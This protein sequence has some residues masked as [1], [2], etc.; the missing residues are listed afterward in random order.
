MRLFV[1]MGLLISFVYAD[2][3]SKNLQFNGVT[4]SYKNKEI[5]IKRLRD[6]KC[7]NVGITP[8]NIFGGNLSGHR[9]PKE[10]KR[11][12]VTS[13]GVVQS[14]KIDDD[15]Q[16]VGE[17]EVLKF[18]QLLDFE[19]E[20]YIVVDARSEK[21][22]KKISI[23]H[24]V[25]VQFLHIKYHEDYF[26]SLEKV[27]APLGVKKDKK[28]KLDFSHAKNAI[29]Y[30]NANWCTQSANMIRELVKLGYPKDKLFWYRGGLQDW[31]GAGFTVSKSK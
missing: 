6:P 20:K 26:E 30:C 12:F 29:I 15:I 4:T 5:F 28:G 11:S 24:A 21:W 8:E 14:M 13:L 16:T 22:F 31:I 19:P 2:E 17:I 3:E 27:L 9:V 10:C 25:N 18:L 7:L 23:P 1:F